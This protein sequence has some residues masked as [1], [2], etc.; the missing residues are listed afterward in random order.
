MN[1]FRSSWIAA[2]LLGLALSSAGIVQAQ[3]PER[4][5]APS[6][7]PERIAAIQ[8]RLQARF[9]SIYA[10]GDFPGASAGFRL[11]D[12]TA[13]T[14]TVGVSDRE[15]GTPME[16]NDRMLTGSVGKTFVAAVALQLVSEGLLD[17]DRLVS[18]YLGN[19]SWYPSLP[20]GQKITVRMLMTHT[21]GIVR[22][23]FNEQFTRD[24]TADPEKVWRPEEL[25]AYILDTEPPF[26]A[27]QGWTYSDT[28][29][30][31][32]GMI[33]ERITGSTLYEEIRTRLLQSLNLTGTV[34]SDSRRIPGLVQGY[35]GP[36][37]PF[38]GTD[39]MLHGG[40]FAINPQFEWAGGG[41]ATTAG[42]LARWAADIYEGRA[43]DPTLLEQA[44]NGVPARQL[45][46]GARYGLGVIIWDT[47]VGPAWGHSGFF[48]GYLTEMRYYP[49]HRFAVAFQANTSVG[50]ALGRSTGA[51]VDEFARIV[52]EEIGRP[53]YG[54]GG[55]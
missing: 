12:G 7:A 21:S 10:A 55:W 5:L 28:N 9:D 49:E 4:A 26:P 33:I 25:V 30:I 32:L 52:I 34:P 13:F 43:Y 11:P 53:P 19:E 2:A 17:L 20:N 16:P 15:A 45:G 54:N 51:I 39:A 46:R 44:L 22:Y 42:D 23:E 37:N 1:S 40:I 29:F 3:L 24:L 47:P 8:G 31:L 36:G 18:E 27:G 38:G 6:F 48:P 14:L 50:R 35:A 41:F